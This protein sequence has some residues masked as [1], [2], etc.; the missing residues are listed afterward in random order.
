MDRE[1]STT[2]FDVLKFSSFISFLFS[3]EKL[4][5]ISTD[6]ESGISSASGKED[7]ASAF[8]P[9]AFELKVT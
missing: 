1:E 8:L 4:L 3:D 7:G 5:K 6:E 2:P 9:G